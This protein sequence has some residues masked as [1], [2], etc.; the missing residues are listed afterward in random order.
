MRP[1]SGGVGVEKPVAKK[2]TSH[3][4][5]LT[6]SLL[7]AAL[8][9][10]AAPAPAAAA[11]SSQR[12]PS[13]GAKGPSPSASP[14]P[15]PAPAPG[16]AGAG[17]QPRLH[18]SPLE[19]L[20]QS[21]SYLGAS[22]KVHTSKLVGRSFSALGALL[23]AVWDAL[24]ALSQFALRLFEIAFEQVLRALVYAGQLVALVLEPLRAALD[25]VHEHG[26]WA[27][28]CVATPPLA[29]LAFASNENNLKMSMT[30]SLWWGLSLA[31]T[32]VL[33]AAAITRATTR[34]AAPAAR[35]TR[36]C[37]PRLCGCGAA[38]DLVLRLAAMPS[39]LLGEPAGLWALSALIATC[40]NFQLSAQACGLALAVLV[41]AVKVAE[42]FVAAPTAAKASAAKRAERAAMAEAAAA[43]Q[44]RD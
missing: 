27:V 26:D 3:T 43:A 33:C 4:S 10:L 35:A 36:S 34:A 37:C 2:G 38:C 32:T 42:L 16:A 25:L 13:P 44:K 21:L 14:S 8:L 39:R 23:S 11:A 29:V 1:F 19:A 17:Q 41:I 6:T 31:V 18:R 40:F 20:E 9:L 28:F 30:M 12:K 7:L 24:V 15:S 5:L 22:L